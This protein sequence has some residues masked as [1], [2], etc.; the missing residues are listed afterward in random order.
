M[1]RRAVAGA[2]GTLLLLLAATLLLPLVVSLFAPPEGA[3]AWAERGAFVLAA[4]AATGL[5]LLLRW[6]GREKADAAIG[7]REGYAIV[8]L[9]WVLAAAVGGVPF[10]VAGGLGPTD[11]FFE[12]M[13][14]FTTT[15]ASIYVN[16]GV[17]SPALL[18]WRA[19]TQW[20]GGLGIVVLCVA[21]LPALGAQVSTLVRAEFTGYGERLRPRIVETARLLWVTYLALTALLVLLLLAGGLGGTDAVCH[22]FSA[23]STGGFGT[24]LDSAAGFSPYVQWVLVL[25]MFLGGT[26]FAVLYALLAQRRP[27]RLTG[28]PEFRLYA[29][30]VLVS[31]AALALALLLADPA[32]HK[33]LQGLSVPGAVRH[34]AFQ[35]V[36]VVTTTGFASS[37]FALWPVAAQVLLFGLLFVGGC[38]GSTSGSIKVIRILLAAKVAAREMWHLLSPRAV[39]PVRLGEETVDRDTVTAVLG[40]MLLF[41]ALFAAGAVL[42][43]ALGGVTAW[44]ALAASASCLANVGPAFGDLGPMNCYA[45]LP[46]LSKWV[47]S[48]EMLLGRLEIYSVLLL[49]FP[50]AWR[51]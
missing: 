36:S 42:V 13:S 19:L 14:G 26:N 38:V 10:M 39:L 25:F 7:P 16:P 4:A 32:R 11:A 34:A 41:L 30:I 17:L 43:A 46:I 28:D 9:G 47:L 37:D 49:C 35:V 33:P 45:G 31:T 21:V 1:S 12:T 40:Y 6:V 2:T 48:A 22:A 23:I 3:S 50:S 20:I 8:T 18:F 5:G 15:G 27:R 44:E 29:A 24:K 51:K